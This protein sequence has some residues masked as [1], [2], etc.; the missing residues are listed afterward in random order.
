MASKD[1]WGWTAR[2]ITLND[3]RAR[4]YFHERQ[5]WWTAI[6]H[7]I[8]DEE[9]GKGN[10]FTRP[11]LIIKK[12]NRSLFY[13]IPLST[14]LKTGKYYHTLTIRGKKRVA[15]LSHMRDYDA[16]RLLN[17]LEVITE[18]EYFHLLLAVILLLKPDE[19]P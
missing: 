12:F 5:V 13:G 19:A 3:G 8:G 9:D 7:N 17:V 1:Y 6:G 16:K 14:N 15:L 18:V 4:P 10:N 2:K 11:V